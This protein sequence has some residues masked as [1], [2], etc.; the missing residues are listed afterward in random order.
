[1]RKGLLAIFFLL[2]LVVSATHNRAGEISFTKVGVNQFEITLIT[3]TRIETEADRPIISINWGDGTVD[4]LV[5]S[6]GFPEFVAT[7]INK[8]EYKA[9]HTFP[10]PGT[11]A[12]SL[13]DPN[14]NADVVNIPGS[15]NV[16]FY[17]ESEIIINPFLGDNA[18]PVLLNPPIEDACV[19]EIFQ[20]NPSA[21][22][23][24]GDSL[25]FTLIEAKGLGGE[26]IG[27]YTIPAGVSL[28]PKTGTLTWDRP[29]IEGEFNFAILIEEYRSGFKIGSMIRDMQVS[30]RPCDNNPP[31]IK[32]IKDICVEAGTEVD[33]EIE[34]TDVDDGQAITLTAT[35]GPLTEVDGDLAVFSE[36]VG[37]DTVRGNFRWTTGCSHVRAEPYQIYFKAQDN[38]SEVQL[39]DLFTYNIK[40]IGPKVKNVVAE[41]TIEG[42]NVT[43]TRSICEEVTGYKV[44]RKIDSLDWKPDSCVVGVPGYTGYEFVGAV[45]GRDNSIF[46]DSTVIQ[47]NRYCYRIVAI[48]PDGSESIASEEGCAITV[49]TKPIPTNADVYITDSLTGGIVV[50]WENPNDLDSMDLS[51]EAFYILYTIVDGVRTEIHRTIDLDES[52]TS[53]A[54][55]NINTKSQ[56]HFYEVDLIDIVDGEE[57]VISS[58]EQFSSVFLSAI[59][60]DRTVTLSWDYSTP[61]NVDSSLIFYDLDL[62]WEYIDTVLFSTVRYN[63]LT[64]DSMYCFTIGTLGSYSIDSSESRTFLNRSQEVC[65]IPRDLVPPC[66]PTITSISDCDIDENRFS[67]FLDTAE[68]NGDLTEVSIYFKKHPEDEYELLIEQNS[69]WVD[70]IFVHS[71]LSEVAG[72]YAFTATDSVGNESGF[73]QEVCFDNCPVYYLPNIFTPNG[74]EFNELVIPF[75]YKYIEGVEIQIFNRWGQR[76]FKTNDIDVNWDGVSSLT[77]LPCSG[78]VYYYT[79]IIKEQRLNGIEDKIINGFIQLIRN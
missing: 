71:D 63:E 23:P 16:P 68:C 75:P 11:Y 37:I 36:V 13:E 59:P 50:R 10:G 62:S 66:V 79:C 41:G 30:V 51:S 9:I 25:T 45:T 43:W 48:F 52:W 46:L 33:F 12:V 58:S 40:V 2:S 32:E 26:P 69:P 53:F 78:G 55:D 70:S 6:D 72:C 7:D 49:E 15:V 44:Y 5:R 61:W 34:A 14:R 67:W 76:V 74:D 73:S 17:I 64:N 42:I 65:V 60:A 35:G 29:A 21:F 47:R 77:G 8:N 31:V 4:S 27:G 56:Q 18:S 19:E 57:K 38:D 20:H 24:D 39:I 54:H 1:M 3:Y 22:D 28:D